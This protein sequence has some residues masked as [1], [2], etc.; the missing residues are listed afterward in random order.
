MANGAK[1]KRVG[2]K[3][4]GSEYKEGRGGWPLSAIV[5]VSFVYCCRCCLPGSDESSGCRGEDAALVALT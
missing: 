2:E 3:A 4:E 5:I 1:V